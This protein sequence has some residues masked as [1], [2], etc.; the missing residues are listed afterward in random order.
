M[1]ELQIIFPVYNEKETIE[2]VLRE[3]KKTI[4]WLNVR[5]KF[6]ICEDGST[7]G[8]AEL[9]P[10]KANKYNLILIQK[11]KR[12]G[13]GQ[14]VINGIKALNSDYILCVDSDGQ[15]DPSDFKSFWENRKKADVIIG[16]RK[17][18]AD[19]L[20]R[21]I[22]SALFGAFFRLLFKTN[23]HDPS[24]PFVLFQKKKILPYLKQLTYLK[25][26]FWWGFVGLCTKKKLSLY[27]IPI[28]HKK[29]L[30]G[31]TNV[32]K[33]NKIIDI[34]LRNLIGLVRL[35]LSQKNLH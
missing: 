12:R 21:K 16:W 17:N 24:C 35:K 6:I 23:I 13:Y 10:K 1:K 29:R 2:I 18:R 26:G 27:E 25:E 34:A 31:E 7:D 33:L 5:Y 30:K 22:F 9:L 15:C 4:E 8:T 14:A 32:Y 28:N 20:L 11:K 19:S 3:W